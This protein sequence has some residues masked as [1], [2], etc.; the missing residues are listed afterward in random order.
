MN[1]RQI[2]PQA[3]PMYDLKMCKVVTKQTTTKEIEPCCE[4][5]PIKERT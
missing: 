2:L 4:G 5:C 3:N 1:W